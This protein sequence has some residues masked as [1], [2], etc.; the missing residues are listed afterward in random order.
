[1]DPW[2]ES[3]GPSETD[4]EKTMNRSDIYIC[5]Y[6]DVNT[7]KENSYLRQ[8]VSNIISTERERASP[9]NNNHKDDSFQTISYESIRRH[10]D[11]K[12]LSTTILRE[13]VISHK[14]YGSWR[15]FS[16][17]VINPL[18]DNFI[19]RVI[20]EIWASHILQ[21]K[22]LPKWLDYNYSPNGVAQG[23]SRAKKHYYSI[24]EK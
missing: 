13:E 16:T 18:R 3:T 5:L 1:M 10:P 6:K 20:R 23:Y 14:P 15:G 2:Y 24:S 7:E 21:T 17:F 22:L 8:V 12:T 9:L 4:V 19:I 11:W